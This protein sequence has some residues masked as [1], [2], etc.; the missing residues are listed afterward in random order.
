MKLALIIFLSTFSLNVF[1]YDHSYDV[2]GTSGNGNAVEGTADSNNGDRNVSGE[3]TDEDGNTHSFEGQWDGHG[4]I[5]GETD[6]GDSVDLDT[7]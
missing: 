4:H 3:V 2:S 5:S 7:D 1:A 6:E